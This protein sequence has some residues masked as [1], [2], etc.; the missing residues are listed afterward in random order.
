SE[1]LKLG[2]DDQK[3]EVRF[4]YVPAQG[5]QFFYTVETAVQPGEIAADNNKRSFPQTVISKK[6]K[7]L[8]VEGEPRYEYR[9]LRNAILRDTSLDFG[10]L[11]LSGDTLNSGGEGNIRVRGFP[12]SE[13]E[14]FEY[15]IIVL[16]D[17][18]RSYF[19]EQQLLALRR[20]VEDRG[21]SLLMV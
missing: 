21:A 5:G 18:P 9:Y 15:D 7:V 3:Q 1:A 11:L 8:Y 12:A 10:C 17:V 14:L 6:L 13:K 19:S 16:G 4:N 2:P 20:F